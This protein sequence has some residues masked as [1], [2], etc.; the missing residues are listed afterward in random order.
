V[1]PV[2]LRLR[3]FL[4]YGEEV[5]ELDFTGFD[6]ACVS[7]KNGHG[8]S[9]L[10][11]AVTWVLWGE[12]RKSGAERKPD[13][14]LVRSGTQ[15]ARV[16]FVFDTQGNRYRVIR[17]FR[18][19]PSGGVASL[20]FQVYDCVAQHY[21][22]L[23]E[24]GSVR[25]TQGRINALLGMGYDTF[26]N[27]ALLLQGQADAFTR[28]SPADRKAILSEILELG[29]YDTLAEA[30][31]IHL[32]E[33]RSGT[34]DAARRLSDI[35][36]ATDRLLTL[37]GQRE[38][39]EA[40]FKTA[41]DIARVADRDLNRAHVQ[42]AEYERLRVDLSQARAE[43]QRLSKEVKEVRNQIGAARH[44]KRVAGRILEDADSIRARSE[45][46]KTIEQLSAQLA[47]RHV[48]LTTATIEKTEIE[49]RIS[50]A[51]QAAVHRLELCQ[52]KEAQAL[53]ALSR[54]KSVLER[55]EEVD[56]RVR[57]LAEL[58]EEGK[59]LDDVLEK[60]R[61][62]ESELAKAQAALERERAVRQSKQASLAAEAERLR[63]AASQHATLG[64]RM[65][66]LHQL[67]GEALGLREARKRIQDEVAHLEKA[68]TSREARVSEWGATLARFA[69]QA[70]D[71]TQADGDCPVC[72][73]LLDQ[74]HRSNAIDRI[75]QDRAELEC[76]RAT[77][78][79]EM[80]TARSKRIALSNAQIENERSLTQL[81]HVDAELV[82]TRIAQEQTQRAQNELEIVDAQLQAA[83][84]LL[85][86][87]SSDPEAQACERYQSE[88]GALDYEA[89]VHADLRREIENRRDANADLQQIESARGE[90][91]H[92]QSELD[93][94]CEQTRVARGVLDA[95]AF[96]PAAREDFRHVEE[97]IAAIDYDEVHHQALER[98]LCTLSDTQD[99]DE[100][101]RI[102]E[103]ERAT[104]SIQI[105]TLEKQLDTLQPRLTACEK[106]TTDIERALETIEVPAARLEELLGEATLAN[107]KRDRELESVAGLRRDC[108]TCQAQIDHRP[109]VSAELKKAERDVIL[110]EH[111]VTAFGRDGIPALIIEQAIPEFELEANAIL[112][113]L[114]N[115]Q[116]RVILDPVRNLKGGGTRESF[117]IRISDDFG[118]RPYELYSG[119]EAF[120]V[121]FALRIALS[122]LLARRTGAPL[123]TLV[124]DEG[125][126]TQDSE[127]VDRLVN[128]IEAIRDDFSKIL[129]ISHVEAIKDA[130]PVTIAVTK[131]ADRGSSFQVLS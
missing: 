69:R 1:I 128:A 40:C 54:I 72:G 100:Q 87:E 96:E 25:R 83:E 123:Q 113:R 47:K 15:E 63:S 66:Q 46:R 112:S 28:R 52:Q 36:A 18:K 39:Q 27:S 33:A 93:R 41:T 13:D 120:R 58:K 88:L 56:A 14:G 61:E 7:G 67:M 74:D 55:S 12:A 104:T 77:V 111:L 124:I 16:E 59:R 34:A 24:S 23:S 32:A 125:F 105:L 92:L 119:G 131:T 3:N 5:D 79:Q 68:Q 81:A 64:D 37:T 116:T 91:P 75:E 48:E 30:A 73:T 110:Y 8:K 102:A 35:E 2:T 130:F 44:R 51:H 94:S 6:V 45:R 62:L 121:D 76:E 50:R 98:E 103:Q 10:F 108:Q 86:H 9:A 31:R 53:D 38:A 97:L 101:L 90:K 42:A 126:G 85:R 84:E 115:D 118:E 22:A 26:V 11:D 127:G 70:E 107:E 17:T 29:R 80:A 99:A 122:K 89:R 60:R 65:E 95:G 109:A 21:Q 106:Q 49:A 78:L 20:E 117:D 43:R 19:R 57:E 82:E 4:S 114:T 71:L 129:V